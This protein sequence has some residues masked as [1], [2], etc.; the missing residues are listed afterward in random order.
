MPGLPG[1]IDPV[2]N[3]AFILLDWRRRHSIGSAYIRDF[4]ERV[5]QSVRLPQV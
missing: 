3:S 1:R 2:E 4:H 5:E